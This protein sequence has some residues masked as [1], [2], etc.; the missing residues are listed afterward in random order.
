MLHWIASIPPAFRDRQ[1][2]IWRQ[3]LSPLSPSASI[4]SAA[5]NG[6]NTPLHAAVAGMNPRYAGW[7]MLNYDVRLDVKNKNG[8][9]P[10]HLAVES[11][12]R[13]MVIGL[14]KDE[15]VS[16]KLLYAHDANGR[17][18]LH[19]AVDKDLFKIVEDLCQVQEATQ[20]SYI[21]YRSL[22]FRFRNFLLFI[23]GSE[24]PQKPGLI[25]WRKMKHESFPTFF[26]THWIT[27]RANW[28]YND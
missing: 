18:A 4:V 20:D 5:D 15:K 19:I 11:G 13:G 25:S 9:T 27:V 24:T 26:L 14:L 1:N 12:L 7:L 2:E 3:L 23:K 17:T 8:S 10:L 21:H 22:N 16:S 28:R 6:G